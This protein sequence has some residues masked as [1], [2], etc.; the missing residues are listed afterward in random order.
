MNPL[1]FE[2]N[3]K[4][5]VHLGKELFTARHFEFVQDGRNLSNAELKPATKDSLSVFDDISAET[6]RSVYKN[7]GYISVDYAKLL[8]R[9]KPLMLKINPKSIEYWDD[10]FGRC[11]H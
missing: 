9:V 4:F 1:S 8:V 5:L 7:P 10:Y 2:F 6:K 11:R 3:S